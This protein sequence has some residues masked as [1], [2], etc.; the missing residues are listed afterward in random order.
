[1]ESLIFDATHASFWR[2][3]HD[4]APVAALLTLLLVAALLRR[5]RFACWVFV[6]VGV[7]GLPSWVAHGVVKHVTTGFVVGLGVG[8]FEL[9][10]LL[11][12]PMRRY[13]G[14]GRWRGR[15]R[16]GIART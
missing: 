2:R 1:M 8:L 5:H 6:I 12:V 14:V 4:T 11:S 16:V 9:A 3:A 7:T 15:Q 10:M 13:V